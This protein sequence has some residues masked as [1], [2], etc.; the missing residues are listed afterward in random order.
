MLFMIL[1]SLSWAPASLADTPPVT[2]AADQSGPVARTPTLGTLTRKD[3]AGPTGHMAG[4]KDQ[5]ARAR[6]LDQ[7][8]PGRL[9][10]AVFREV[11]GCP[12]R[13]VVHENIGRQG[14]PEQGTGR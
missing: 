7:L 12:I 6:R 8:P 11:G 1:L 9:E 13:A 14:S 10:Y 3:C 2:T 4:R 5:G